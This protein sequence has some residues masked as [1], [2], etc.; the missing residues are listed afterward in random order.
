MTSEATLYAT[1]LTTSTK[2]SKKIDQLILILLHFL[3]SEK[4]KEREQREWEREGDTTFV[5]EVD[6]CGAVDQS[7]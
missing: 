5:W 1:C 6:I 2:A 7:I 4:D 3:L